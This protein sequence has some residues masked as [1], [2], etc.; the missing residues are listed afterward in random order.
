[1]LSQLKEEVGNVGRE[2]FW[3]IPVENSNGGTGVDNGIP[4][5]NFGSGKVK[6]RGDTKCYQTEGLKMRE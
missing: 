1:M 2:G 4:K 5:V 3:T 6:D